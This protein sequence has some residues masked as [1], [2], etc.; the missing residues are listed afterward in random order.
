MKGRK[1]LV[2]LSQWS[3]AVFPVEVPRG[4]SR[5]FGKN[6]T[7]KWVLVISLFAVTGRAVGEV[8][9]I[10]SLAI[11]VDICS[12]LR[13]SQ[14]SCEKSLKT[15]E[16]FWWKVY[17]GGV[18]VGKSEKELQ[19]NCGNII[20]SSTQNNTIKKRKNKQKTKQA[21]HTFKE[22]G[23]WYELVGISFSAISYQP[24]TGGCGPTCLNP[25]RQCEWK[26]DA[27]VVSLQR[28]SIYAKGVS[29]GLLYGG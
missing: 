16:S 24:S 2:W 5:G 27:S 20:P 8:L 6:L 9:S 4:C 11:F 14:L 21:P 22:G 10:Q 12:I 19:E 26:H 28:L 7:W 18:V 3:C 17:A 1:L 23:F 29:W 25:E 13:E 15:G